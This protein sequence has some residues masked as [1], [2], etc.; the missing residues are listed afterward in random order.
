M[1][2]NKLLSLLIFI[3][4][5][6]AGCSMYD[7]DIGSSKCGEDIDLGYFKLIPKSIEDW[8]PYKEVNEL[9]FINAEGGIITLQIEKREEEMTRNVNRVICEEST[10]D[11]ALEIYWGEWLRVEYQGIYNDVNYT[12]YALLQVAGICCYHEEFTDLRLGDLITYHLE[13]NNDGEILGGYYQ[14]YVNYRGNTISN[15]DLGISPPD[16]V[17]E[18]E[19]N[20]K[21]F[22]G[23]WCFSN[24]NG[25]PMLYVQ[26]E[27]GIIAFQG[28]NNEVWTLQ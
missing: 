16:F 1:M 7:E 2:K 13:M 5:I 17:Q 28:L 26:Q 27:Q 11:S 15:A 14:D 23:I 12:F 19:I 20:G 4:L 10:F 24:S 22:N 9:T 6:F 21:T 18:I 3:S 25:F 8:F